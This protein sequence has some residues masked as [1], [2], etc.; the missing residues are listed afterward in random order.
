MTL[1]PTV[2]PTSP[3]LQDWE[4]ERLLWRAVGS[5]SSETLA[6]LEEGVTRAL[7]LALSPHLE[8]ALW[9][10][11][12]ESGLHLV[13]ASARARRCLPPYTAEALIAATPETPGSP[14]AIPLLP[15][16]DG[17]PP[18]VVLVEGSEPQSPTHQ[19]PLVYGS[20]QGLCTLWTHTTS[21]R[22]SDETLSAVAGPMALA[23]ALATRTLQ[24]RGAVTS[25][26]AIERSPRRQ[27]R[28]EDAGGPDAIIGAEGGL[29][30]VL[31][32]VDRVATLDLPVLLLGETG[33]G[34]ELIAR[35]IHDQSHCAGG[36]LV[37]V[38]CGAIP[39]ELIDSELFGH[40]RGAFTGAL[41]SREG[42]FERAHGGTLMLDEIGD[43]PAAAQVRLLRVLQEGE[44]TRVGGTQ[45]RRVRVRVVA[46]THHDLESMVARQA[47]R[48]DLWF[49]LSV[50][51][52]RIPPLRNR[53]EDIPALARFFGARSAG[54][55]GAP[56]I[57]PT[58]EDLDALLAYD[59]PGNIRELAAVIERAVILGD[60][61]RFDIHRALGRTSHVSP[62]TTTPLDPTRGVPP[63]R[64][65]PSS[66]SPAPTPSTTFEQRV[67][68]HI[69]EALAACEGR[70][71][72]P[73][74]A[75]AR[76]HLAPSTLRSKMKRLGIARCAAGR[77]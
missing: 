43:L 29:A 59:W 26:L 15:A 27:T 55:L 51:P 53:L 61:R 6:G 1:N 7:G 25:A 49:R 22:C 70:I 63:D 40:E 50:F 75:A 67:R 73:T 9:L 64:P 24:P 8:W 56:A 32:D 36:P 17:Q 20:L 62:H 58:Q 21:L 68:A 4:L 45:T 38:N 57:E 77:P 18:G 54:R 72:G 10:V 39:P 69:V 30:P 52:I 23:M 11:T 19:F 37:R 46:A 5:P 71:E 66:L 35:R 76:L 42:W 16:D 74:G 33:S 34:K 14:H 13:A 3:P 31:A 12:A 2:S 47:F 28:L 44:I 41:A 65:G 48:Q 60:G